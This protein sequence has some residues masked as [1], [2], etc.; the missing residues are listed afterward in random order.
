MKN[1]QLKSYSDIRVHADGPI[2]TM[3]VIDPSVEYLLQFKEHV[4]VFFDFK[5]LL[6]LLN[7]QI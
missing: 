2:K 7:H 5:Q 1:T 3:N 6:F 4:G